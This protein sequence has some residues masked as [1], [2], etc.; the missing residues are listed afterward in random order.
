MLHYKYVC[1]TQTGGHFGE[2][3]AEPFFSK[4]IIL[5][6]VFCNI[7]FSF[8][9]SSSF[10]FLFIHFLLFVYV[11]NSKQFPTCWT[12]LFLIFSLFRYTWLHLK[13]REISFVYLNKIWKLL[14]ACTIFAT[15]KNFFI[16]TFKKCLMVKNEFDK[17][18]I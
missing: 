16:C 4:I 2:W 8:F 18:C 3:K 10:V 13:F 1:E 7:G 12:V 14:D 11:G 6:I 5:Q 15:T 17:L 9:L